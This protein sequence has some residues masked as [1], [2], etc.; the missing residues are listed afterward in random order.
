MH[1]LDVGLIGKRKGL[2][3]SLETMQVFPQIQSINKTANKQ[4]RVLLR[5]ES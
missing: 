2:V 1:K 4:V 5:L 3:L